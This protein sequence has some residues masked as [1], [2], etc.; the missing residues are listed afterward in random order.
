MFLNPNIS[1]LCCPS[2]PHFTIQYT[3]V[4]VNFLLF[5]SAAGCDISAL[6]SGVSV[7]FTMHCLAE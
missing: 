2:L 4:S 5:D 1:A 3:P 7:K 6:S